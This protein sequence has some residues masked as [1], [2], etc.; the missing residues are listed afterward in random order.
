MTNT[1]NV[2]SN[3]LSLVQNAIINAFAGNDGKSPARIGTTLFASRFY[4]T[5]ASL[6]DWAQIISIKVGST[7][8]PS[9]VFTGSITGNQLTVSAV[10]SGTIA[11]GQRLYDATGNLA[12]D[13]RIVALGT[14]TG[15]T[16]TYTVSKTFNVLS[17][18][19]QGVSQNRDDILVNIN[20]I[21][22]TS[23]TE[24]TMTLSPP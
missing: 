1:T 6:G 2:P 5:I 24:I 4:S 7:N 21:P 11:I 18:T 9:S 3:A 16:G 12:T 14:G 13:T 10:T 8:T 23:L 19:M 17:K 22:T 15:G 20:Q